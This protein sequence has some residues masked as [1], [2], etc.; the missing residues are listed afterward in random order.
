M[1]PTPPPPAF[2]L[3]RR[4]RILDELHRSG[5]VR[6]SDLARDLGVAELTVRRD[7]GA[8]ADQGLLTRVHGGATLRSA[9]DT[10]IPQRRAAGPP[11]YRVG[12]IV[13]SLSYY[14]PQIILG[15]RAAASATGV[16]LVLRGASYAVDDQRRQIASLL[17]GESL[18]G[19][20]VAAETSG[21]EG[22]TLLQWL[23]DIPLPVVLVERHAPSALGLTRVEWVTSD[24]VVGGTLAARHLA[25]R[26]HRRVG[27]LTSPGSPT[28]APL[29]KGWK[30]AVRELGLVA[31]VD[32]SA[33]LDTLAGTRR[34]AEIDRILDECRR[35]GTTALTIHSDPQA[36][37][38]QQHARDR[39]W[40]LPADLAIVAYDDEVAE[41]A[42]PPITALR[43]PK[44]QVG[45]LAVETMAARLT[46]GR[47]R[48][49][50]RTYL[51]PEL[52]RR[53]S[54]AR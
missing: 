22:A 42:E 16:Q 33:A 48:P 30:R 25:E 52:R 43:P 8:L 28:S 24:H 51:L 4:E 38:F 34:E 40:N 41:S 32:S 13:P 47:R 19:L 15:A 36:V 29:R 20:I 9:L 31:T 6:V 3:T 53:E 21:P 10:S 23:D 1:S 17:D 5:S 7:I 37:L 39:G 49:V 12:M 11:K 27:L 46:D 44:Q 14:W 35:T 45:R 50:Q 2:G 54:T 26:G 18:H